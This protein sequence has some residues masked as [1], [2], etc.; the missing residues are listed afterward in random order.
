[1]VLKRLASAQIGATLVEA[2]LSVQVFLLI[3][4]VGIELAIASYRSA[5]LNYSVAQATRWAILNRTIGN[6]LR[7]PSIETKVREIAQPYGLDLSQNSN[8]NV[9][10]PAEVVNQQTGECVIERAGVPEEYIQ[11]SANTSSPML[12][13]FVNLDLHAKALGRNEP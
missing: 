9:C 5:A 4:V 12:F 6:Q 13:G 8:I 2:A 7:V 3:V 10:R 1:M 11:V